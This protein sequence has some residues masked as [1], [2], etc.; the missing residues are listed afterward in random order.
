MA[1]LNTEVVKYS[2]QVKGFTAFPNDEWLNEHSLSS[3][4]AIGW[5]RTGKIVGKLAQLCCS[6]G[7]A[8]CGDDRGEHRGN[9]G[10]TFGTTCVS[11]TFVIIS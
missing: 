7:F 9:P 3:T 11:I 1:Q 2:E 10:Q 5:S 8:S 6:R 4:D